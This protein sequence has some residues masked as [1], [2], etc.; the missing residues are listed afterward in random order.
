MDRVAV[1]IEGGEELARRLRQLGVDAEAVLREAAL[2]GARLFE[3]DMGSRSPDAVYIESVVVHDSR[4]QASVDVGPTEDKWYWKFL[5]TR[6]T[7]Y[8][9]PGPLAFRV[10][11]RD[12]VIGAADHPGMAARPFM[13]PAFDGRQQAATDAVGDVLRR[14]LG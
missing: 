7:A 8:E 3:E 1:Q 6:E 10:D 11:G 9:I 13:R 12:L 14:T 4:R 2:A 5:Y